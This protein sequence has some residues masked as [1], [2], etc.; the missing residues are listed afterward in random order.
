MCGAKTTSWVAGLFVVLG[1]GNARVGEGWLERT[2]RTFR[3][4]LPHSIS[5]LFF[6]KFQI[7]QLFTMLFCQYQPPP[8]VPNRL[9]LNMTTRIVFFLRGK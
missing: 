2:E 4:S 8:V 6:K 5:T 7:S 3:S 9:P 1:E